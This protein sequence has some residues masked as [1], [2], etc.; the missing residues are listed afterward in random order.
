MKQ[1]CFLHGAVLTRIVKRARPVSLTLIETD[2]KSWSG[3]T[4]NDYVFFI[5]ASTSPKKDNKGATWTFKI[6]SSE[7]DQLKDYEQHRKVFLTLVCAGESLNDDSDICLLDFNDI[8]NCLNINER[9]H[10]DQLLTIKAVPNNCLRVYGSVNKR[11]PLKIARNKLDN[12]AIP[13]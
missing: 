4:L 1:Y 6:S 10:C 8:T 11:R 9:R 7:I 12:L 3:Y 5:K 2:E 13:S